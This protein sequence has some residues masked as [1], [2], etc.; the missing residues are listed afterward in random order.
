M[1]SFLL[2][3]LVMW[4]IVALRKRKKL[5]TGQWVWTADLKN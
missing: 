2:G 5:K 3:A 1:L 4:I